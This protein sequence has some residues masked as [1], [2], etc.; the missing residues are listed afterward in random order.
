MSHGHASRAHT[1]SSSAFS[2]RSRSVRRSCCGPGRRGSDV[3]TRFHRPRVRYSHFLNAE[4][5]VPAS[6]TR[7]TVRWYPARGALAMRSSSFP[8]ECFGGQRTF[9]G[10][11]HQGGQLLVV[12]LSF[13]YKDPH[14]SQTH[15]LPSGWLIITLQARGRTRK[16]D[17]KGKTGGGVEP[18]RTESGRMKAEMVDYS[19]TRKTRE[20]LSNHDRWLLSRSLF[21]KECSLSFWPA[22]SAA[23]L[24]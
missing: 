14:F 18:P 17:Q 20:L 23:S 3:V 4:G 19:E 10:T 5:H 21:W 24:T 1:R 11:H 8:G 9:R 2:V 6:R 13:P 12:F 16:E 22:R 7:S 15:L